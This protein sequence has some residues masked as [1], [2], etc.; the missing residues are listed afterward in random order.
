MLIEQPIRTFFGGVSR[1]P[2][3]VRRENQVE[4]CI[5]ALNSIVTGGFEKRP[6]AQLLNKLTTLENL[7]L[8]SEK[9]DEAGVWVPFNVPTITLLEADAAQHPY[10]N[11]VYSVE[12]NDPATIEAI[13]QMYVCAAPQTEFMTAIDVRLDPSSIAPDV[14]LSVTT[15][16]PVG[17]PTE[18]WMHVDLT[19][20]V[21][22][23]DGGPDLLF[24]WADPLGE[25][26]YRLTIW[27]DKPVDGDLVTFRI[28]PGFIAA[29]MG[30]IW[31]SR[32]LFEEVVDVDQE[33]ASPYA[34]TEGTAVLRTPA[35]AELGHE[36]FKIHGINRDE[37]EQYVLL[38]GNGSI[39]LYDGV[40]GD[41]KQVIIE[42][43]EQ[44]FAT[45]M[46]TTPLNTQRIHEIWFDPA[47]TH[48]NFDIHWRAVTVGAAEV[49]IQRSDD[50]VVW[51]NLHTQALAVGAGSANHNA[52]ITASTRY[53]RVIITVARAGFVSVIGTFRSTA[54]LHQGEPV[55]ED[56]S[57]VSLADT[58]FI[59]NTNIVPRMGRIGN[60]EGH[61]TI[62]GTWATYSALPAPAAG[63]P[64]VGSLYR[65]SGDD[66]DKFSGYWLVGRAA[67]PAGGTR[68]YEETSSPHSANFVDRAAWPWRLRKTP[69]GRFLLGS[70]PWNPRPSGDV[71]SNPQ[72]TFVDKHIS[73]I[74]FYRG[75]FGILSDESVILSRAGAVYDFFA[76]KAIDVLDT[77]PIDRMANT[78]RV[79]IMSFATPFRKALVI[80]SPA[81]QFELASFET[82]TPESAVLDPTTSYTA[83]PFCQPVTMGDTLYFAVDRPDTIGIME[84]YHDEDSLTNTAVD[85]TSH[86]P[87][88]FISSAYA[89]AS[90]S[91]TGTIY[92]LPSFSDRIY[93]YKTFWDNNEKVLSAW[94]EYDFSDT[95]FI[96]GITV[97][98]EYLVA[99]ITE[100]DKTFLVQIPS[101]TE[102]VHAG[103]PYT[104]LLDFRTIREDGE[105]D[106]ITDTTTWT[107]VVETTDET[108]VILAAGTAL[109]GTILPVE[110]IGPHSVTVNGD[111]SNTRVYIG[112]NYEMR[113]KLS[114]IFLRDNAGVS[115]V[116]GKLMLHK[117]KFTHR[118]TAYYKIVTEL[119][120][121]PA[122][123]TQYT[124]YTTD[125]GL[126]LLD[127]FPL[128]EDHHFSAGIRG[129]NTE[130]SVSVVNDA[131]LPCTIVAATWRG[132]YTNI[133][134]SQ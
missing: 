103:M 117:I 102:Q 48:I 22:I 120:Y 49:R 70:A 122:Y 114:T 99:V 46:P 130:A 63:A 115:M 81:S 112:R 7:F 11:A 84:Y 83:S 68:F 88:Y 17:P 21:I 129:K 50:R 92:L 18:A 132:F 9:F 19:T 113:V 133:A 118:N 12:D 52:A 108:R 82:L 44:Y 3:S 35:P 77:D 101:D 51:V 71:E 54:L 104:P 75:R 57:A 56:Y 20:G 14:Y 15:S 91:T 65:V 86:V 41:A 42:D 38:L 76:E 26:W 47:E 94:S 100:D 39:H 93:V 24:S 43:S 116:G 13:E 110:A 95:T 58:T 128:Q 107:T 59:C 16:Y 34:Y 111:Y 127:A 31:L 66:S 2:N 109:P 32:A 79:A 53:I 74:F 10:G 106:A 6:A 90:E 105:Y 4:D 36:E 131:P 123:E 96:Q 64:A 45:D 37:Q 1:Q 98:G 72:P 27:T 89:L 62:A 80:T 73:N 55:P 28:H 69:Q 29:D 61:T 33:R 121:R 97:F 30:I 5:N 126:T 8:W 119:L 124:A 25:G 87:G 67:D 60:H 85:V 40:T 134:R 23:G 78:E 125:S